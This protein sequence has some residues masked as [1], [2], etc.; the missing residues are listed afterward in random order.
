M[1]AVQEQTLRYLFGGP[2]YALDKHAQ[3]LIARDVVDLA[4][5]ERLTFEPAARVLS[6]RIGG[7]ANL[8]SYA[9]CLVAGEERQS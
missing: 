3:E 9:A 1:I 2:F 6:Q 5:E 8:A 4:N 7:P